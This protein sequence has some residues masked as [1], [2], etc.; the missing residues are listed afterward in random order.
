MISSPLA[1]VSELGTVVSSGWGLILATAAIVAGVGVATNR[2]RIEWPAAW[3]AASGLSIYAITLW[4]IVFTGGTS[5]LTQ[6]FM[7][8]AAV[9]FMVTR[10]LFCAAHAAKLRTIHSGETGPTHVSN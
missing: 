8:S 10:A 5:G 1:I 3:F 4:W 7:V 6:A 2:Y 9:L